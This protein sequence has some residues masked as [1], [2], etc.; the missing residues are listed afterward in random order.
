MRPFGIAHFTL[1]AALATGALACSSGQSSSYT[2]NEDGTAGTDSSNGGGSWSGSSGTVDVQKEPFETEGTLLN[3][4]TFVRK[5]GET[6]EG[7]SQAI[8]G[9]PE[10]APQLQKWNTGTRLS[11]G[12]VIYYNSPTRPTDRTAMKVQTE[13]MGNA[14]VSYEVKKGDTLSKVAQQLYGELR[15]W[16]ELAAL[17]PEIPNPDQ[18]TPGTQLKIQ[19][20]EGM[21]AAA[22]PPEGVSPQGQVAQMQ[23]DQVVPPP[24]ME[25]APPEP[26]PQMAQTTPQTETA[27]P[28][29]PETAPRSEEEPSRAPASQDEGLFGRVVGYVNTAKGFVVDNP[30]YGAAAGLAILMIVAAVVMKKRRET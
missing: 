26:P 3:A 25:A 17:N 18:V 6:W 8:Y 23:T 15:S 2:S 19:P 13:D 22:P 11:P 1:L 21:A 9:M 24:P 29:P 5:K 20:A 30:L 27:P 7:M 14:L 16:R 28:P 4:F 10:R 12:N